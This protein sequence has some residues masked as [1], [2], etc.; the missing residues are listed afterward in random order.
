MKRIQYDSYGD[1]SVMYL[2]EFE[3]PPLQAGEIAV[4]VKAAS[5][6]PFDWKVRRGDLKMMTG[7]AFPRAMGM[8]FSGIVLSTGP[9]VRRVKPGDEVF[10]LARLKESGAFGEALV[11]REDFLAVKPP[12]VSFEQAACLPTGA[13]T[14]WIGLVNKAGIK[15]AQS[16]F[17]NGCTG[18]VGQAA[19]QLAV[20]L[21]AQVTGSCS[22]GSQTLAREIGVSRI[23]DYRTMDPAQLERTFDVVFDTSGTM[24]PSSG[25][26]L[27]KPGGV[28]LDIHP[29]PA[30]FLRS[31]FDRR[32]KVV[33]CNATAQILD[34]IAKAAQAGKLRIAVGKTVRLEE[35]IA[36]IT[37]LERGTKI[38]GKGLIAVQP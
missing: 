6:N 9:G 37:A 4:K 38:G 21:G 14:A 32:L 7:R 27:L 11:N 28:F 20:M 13:I 12:D 10:G 1:P 26:K 17:I 8:D 24:P 5:I 19:V 23:L 34:G 25:M 29:T 30:K 18:T 2:A 3:L 22:S 36:L 35:S 15:R 31:V 33:I 16:V